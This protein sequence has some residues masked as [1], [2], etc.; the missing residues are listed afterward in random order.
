MLM[1]LIC[2]SGSARQTLQEACRVA[3]QFVYNEYLRD[4]NLAIPDEVQED[5]LV[6]DE[7]CFFNYLE[8]FFN[9]TDFSVFADTAEYTRFLYKEFN[10]ALW[11][12]LHSIIFGAD[13][14]RA[15]KQQKDYM[16]NKIVKPFGISVEAAFRRIEVM[17]NLIAYFPPPSSRGKPATLK[18][19][20]DF[21]E[22]KKISNTIKR[23]MKY[24]LLPEVFNDRFDEL[25]MD[26]TEMNKNLGE[27]FLTVKSNAHT[28]GSYRCLPAQ[29][30]PKTKNK[31]A[32][33][34]RVRM[35][36]R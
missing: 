8:K 15:F 23:E 29:E 13:A 12:N 22:I 30:T 16:L 28:R 24:N 10:R 35:V 1:Q 9:L 5:V 27:A 3:R 34:A 19:W 2:K 14:Y 25:E 18:Q 26:W 20:N 7:N 21:Q 31:N 17:T 11:N 32:V 4:S 33:L 36:P 6:N